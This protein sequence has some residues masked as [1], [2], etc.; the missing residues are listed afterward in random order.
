[1]PRWACNHF[2]SAEILTRS[3]PF[4]IG[5]KKAMVV[6]SRVSAMRILCTASALPAQ[7]ARCCSVTP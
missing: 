6:L 1:M 7:D 4:T 2:N 3:S 5:E